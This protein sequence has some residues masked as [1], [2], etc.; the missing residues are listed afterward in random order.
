MILAAQI[1]DAQHP[2]LLSMFFA[3]ACPIIA[4]MAVR[5][6]GAWSRERKRNGELM[7]IL[8]EYR[9]HAHTEQHGPLTVDGIRFPREGR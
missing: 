1:V 4:A 7:I 3:I 9:L 5:E 8:R 6:V 2:D